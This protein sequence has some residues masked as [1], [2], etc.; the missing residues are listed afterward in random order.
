MEVT[1]VVLAEKARPSGALAKEEVPPCKARP[2]PPPTQY[3]DAQTEAER[4]Q[5]FAEGLTARGWR[6]LRE[7]RGC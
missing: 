4:G 6:A 1:A 7:P 2:P 3:T 5:W